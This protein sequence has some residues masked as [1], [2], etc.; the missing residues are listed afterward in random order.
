V[1][2]EAGNWL[3][4]VKESINPATF[5]GLLTLSGGEVSSADGL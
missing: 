4:F 3:K 5:R 1:E 2:I